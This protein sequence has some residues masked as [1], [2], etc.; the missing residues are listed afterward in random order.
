[1][2][3]RLNVLLTFVRGHRTFPKAWN[4][5]VVKYDLIKYLPW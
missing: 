4:K 3:N 2:I 5:D 1:M